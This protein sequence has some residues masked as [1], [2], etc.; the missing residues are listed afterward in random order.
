FCSI[1]CLDAHVSDLEKLQ[2]HHQP[3]NLKTIRSLTTF[4]FTLMFPDDPVL[5]SAPKRE[6]LDV[7]GGPY[8]ITRFRQHVS[9][10]KYVDSGTILFEICTPLEIEL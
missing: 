5:R 4:M 9:T 2:S 10:K 1:F 7:W 3:H 6:E 8:T